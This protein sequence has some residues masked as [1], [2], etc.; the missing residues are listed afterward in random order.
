MNYR[1][2]VHQYSVGTPHM[3]GDGFRVC[4]YIPGPL[5]LQETLSPFLLL[6]YNPPYHFLPAEKPRGVDVHP[7][8]GF[9]TVT[10]VFEG[11]IAHADSNGN[12]GVIGPDDVQWMTA[13]SG[14]LHKEFQT[15]DFTRNGGNQHLMQL[16]VNLPAKNKLT[17]PAY[18]T[19]TAE[20]IPVVQEGQSRI[21]VIAGQY[22][23]TTGPAHSFSPI[24]VLDVRLAP[25]R[26]FGHRVPIHWNVMGLVIE[27]EIQYADKSPARQGDF[28]V[29]DHEQ[30]MIAFEAG[31][32]GARVI[33]L[34]GEPLNE[35]I[36][37]YGPFVMNTSEEIRTA[38]QEFHTGQF[39]R[40]G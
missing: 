32:G 4:Q 19:L 37:A 35:P 6:D 40:L 21:R 2:I 29:W 7:H 17:P 13:G 30:E 27:G 3:V 16:W 36:V 11:G 18:Q 33:V 10:L 26:A 39:G 20:D 12:A 28:M 14:I 8:K 22:E 1:K 9:E 23:G 25:G 38:L 5:E 24:H 31:T 15:T 34:A